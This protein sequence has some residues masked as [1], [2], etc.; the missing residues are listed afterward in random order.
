MKIEKKNDDEAT[1]GYIST[2]LGLQLL[3]VTDLVFTGLGLVLGFG[4]LIDDGP[5][6]AQFLGDVPKGDVRIG[7][8]HLG[9]LFTAKPIKEKK[10]KK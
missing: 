1:F 4:G 3:L 5:L 10:R 2:L 7:C 8:L 6:F 9:T